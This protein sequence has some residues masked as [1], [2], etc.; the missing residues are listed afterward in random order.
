VGVSQSC[1]S[2]KRNVY[3]VLTYSE[4]KNDIK[5]VLTRL[6]VRA[7]VKCNILVHSFSI[8][9]DDRSKPPPKR[10]LHI[11]R[12]RASSFKWEYPLLSPSGSARSVYVPAQHCPLLTGV[13]APAALVGFQVLLRL[14][15]WVC[16]T[17]FIITLHV[18]DTV[19]VHLQE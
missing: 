8:L 19:R 3:V 5:L 15:W 2:I 12:S 4:K 17:W 13:T 16:F 11:V 10:C 7:N 18:S 9:S 1:G 6:F 14:S